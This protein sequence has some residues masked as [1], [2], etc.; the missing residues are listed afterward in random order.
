MALSRPLNKL[1]FQFLLEHW[2]GKNNLVVTLIL[3]CIVIRFLFYSIPVQSNVVLAIIISVMSIAL[4]L[5]QLVGTSRTIDHYIKAKG[6]ILFSW[7]SY[8]V[9]ILICGLCILQ[10]FDQLAGNY[11]K[12]SI[13]KSHTHRPVLTISSDHSTAYIKGNI[14]H[15]T[16]SALLNTLTDIPEITLISL[17]SDGGLIYAARALALKI[18][19]K[20]LNTH[21]AKRCNSACTLVFLAGKNRTMSKGAKIGFHQYRFEKGNPLQKATAKSEQEKDQAYFLSRNI[22]KGFVEQVFRA[23]PDSLWFP[24]PAQLSAA[25]ILTHK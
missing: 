4:L 24:S 18:L 25:N 19:E 2:R 3:S 23:K 7:L 22:E 13:L 15:E 1:I 20:Q 21:V 11:D 9:L 16:N 8:G 12:I 14:D 6:D 17:N 10:V 5:W